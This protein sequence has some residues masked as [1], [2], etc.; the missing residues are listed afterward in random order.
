[1]LWWNALKSVER[2]V[3]YLLRL[4]IVTPNSRRRSIA[5]FFFKLSNK[6]ISHKETEQNRSRNFWC[7]VKCN[8]THAPCQMLRL[9]NTSLSSILLQWTEISQTILFRL[10]SFV[11]GNTDSRYSKCKHSCS[12]LVW[13]LECRACETGTCKRN[14]EASR[15]RSH[16]RRFEA[17]HLRTMPACDR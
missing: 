6:N 15:I 16:P 7:K 8:L 5:K 2:F 12:R 11:S 10:S 13:S 4:R 3:L 1:M 14:S 17:L 9:I